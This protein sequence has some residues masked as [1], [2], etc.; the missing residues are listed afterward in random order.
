MQASSASAA[1][2]RAMGKSSSTVGRAIDG[3]GPGPAPSQQGDSK[4]Q[5]G[6]AAVTWA[7]GEKV[8][9]ILHH[10]RAVQAVGVGGKGQVVVAGML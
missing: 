9:D 10:T 2:A 8:E 3:G 6:Q 4:G 5:E 7:C 1:I